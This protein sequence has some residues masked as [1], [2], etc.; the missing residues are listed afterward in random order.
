MYRTTLASYHGRSLPQSGTPKNLL[1]MYKH[2]GLHK[3]ACQHLASP[4]KVI[5]VMVE[6]GTFIPLWTNLVLCSGCTLE[7]Y[8]MGS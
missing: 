4:R 5:L 3:G 8:S 6:L 1:Y 7:E 2:S